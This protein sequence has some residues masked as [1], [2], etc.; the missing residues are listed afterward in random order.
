MNSS[1][2]I[3][4]ENKRTLAYIGPKI[5]YQ[6]FLISAISTASISL[7]AAD[8]PISFSK[9]KQKLYKSVYNNEGETFYVRCKWSKKKVD[10]SSCG[11]ENS[12]STKEM[13]R[14]KRI[15]A[16]HVLYKHTY[17]NFLFLY[18]ISISCIV[19]QFL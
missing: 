13:K 14:A 9:A 15:E 7:N 4:T 11:L 10:L 8:I 19:L 1:T 5:I 18:F 12:F 2:F 3:I 17:S 6:A 16:E